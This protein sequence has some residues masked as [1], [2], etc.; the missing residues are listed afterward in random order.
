MITLGID[1]ATPDTAVAV[2]EGGE[3]LGERR[4][5]P[6]PDGRP[7][8]GPELIGLVEELVEGLGDWDRVGLVA[9][10]VGP[11]SFT[12]IRIGV[13]TARAVAQA[14]GLPIASVPSTGAL[15]A[16]IGQGEARTRVAVIDA[17]RSEIFAA[18]LAPGEQAAGAPVVAAPDRLVEVCPGAAGGLAAGDGAIRFR[19]VL[20]GL[21]IEVPADGD[22]AHRLSARH[23]C[24]L[25]ARADS[26]PPEDV[27]PMYLR[28]PDAERWR[29]RDGSD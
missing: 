13:A 29:E 20:E 27:R 6:G 18:A 25:G 5:G 16:G 7:R 12:G 22:P 8:H 11:G 1:T 10:G 28:R 19:G 24:I 4:I 3:T 26:G 17:R 21:G 14:R 9:V 2:C 23:V 15:A